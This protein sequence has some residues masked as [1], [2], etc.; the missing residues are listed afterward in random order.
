MDPIRRRRIVHDQ[1]DHRMVVAVGRHLQREEGMRS[2]RRASSTLCHILQQAQE[3]RAVPVLVAVVRSARAMR[4]AQIQH[5][6]DA[7]A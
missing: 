5:A 6:E 3:R 7:R 2:D 4:L 1:V